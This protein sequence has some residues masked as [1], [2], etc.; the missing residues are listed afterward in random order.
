MAGSAGRHRLVLYEHSLVIAFTVLF[1]GSTVNTVGG[2]AEHNADC[3]N[4]A[5]P[6]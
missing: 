3:D 1:I 5:K 6:P 2:L 4:T